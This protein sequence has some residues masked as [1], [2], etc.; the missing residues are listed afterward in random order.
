[1]IKHIDQIL[2]E[3]QP[4]WVKNVHK[5]RGQIVLAMNDRSGR[6]VKLILPPVTHP[7]CIS[8]HVTPETIRHSTDLRSLISKKA[9]QLVSNTE[10]QIY[11]ENN[12]QAAEA[13]T[14]AFA[15]QEYNNPEISKL[16]EVGNKDDEMLYHKQG[17]AVVAGDRPSNYPEEDSTE[18]K[19]L[20]D[21][22]DGDIQARVKILVEALNSRE[23]K[24]REVRSDL[25]MLDLT[26][27]D[28]A[29]LV[30]N[31]TGLVETY[32]KKE[33]ASRRGQQNLDFYEESDE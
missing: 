32:A 29:Y 27:A 13:V 5:P 4:V 33:F 23:K 22:E 14:S 19:I 7:I 8:S 1:M 24:A 30:A 25:E 31:T 28:L 16:R 15:N 12:P 20:K 2:D 9:I 17:Q 10:A 11:Y 26:D 18:I 6:V 21:E 3:N